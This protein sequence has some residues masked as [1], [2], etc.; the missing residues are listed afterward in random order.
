VTKKSKAAYWSTIL[1]Q[2][3]EIMLS[4]RKGSLGERRLGETPPPSVI[5]AVYQSSFHRQSFSASEDSKTA[6]RA[7]RCLP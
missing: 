5:A 1:R 4:L 6:R 3:V 2:P 7:R